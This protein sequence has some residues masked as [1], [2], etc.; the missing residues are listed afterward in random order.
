ME[1]EK[2]R[3]ICDKVCMIAR[4]AGQF[5]LDERSTFSIDRVENKGVNDFVSYVDKNAEKIIVKGLTPL[6]DDA[7]F[8]TEEKTVTQSDNNKYTW[9]IDPLDGTTNYIHG[10]NPYAVSIGLTEN[11]KLVL[12]VVYIADSKEC[13]Y[14]WKDS[15]AYLNGSEI[16]ASGI[17]SI[18]NS[19]VISG[20]PHKVNQ[21]ID[22]YLDII[23]YLT[24]NSH[25]VRR[26]GSAAADLVY[27]ACGRAEAF[28]QTDLNPWDV[29]AGAFIATRA[30]AVVTDFD[31][32]DNYLF[33]NSLIA[34]GNAELNIEMKNL[35][36]KHFS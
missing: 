2:Y 36:K 13:F 22:N 5:M 1:Y 20:F 14:A 23:K 17:D 24:F 31:G 4:E 15:K 34:T 25:G 18:S 28:F 16:K 29:A 11:G 6:I 33:G 26:V 12:G 30:G 3:E 9:I 27:I 32:G 10:F 19:L 7:G 35:L 8:I 21:K